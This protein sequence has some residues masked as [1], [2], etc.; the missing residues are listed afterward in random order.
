MPVQPSY[1]LEQHVDGAQV[2]DEQVRVYVQRLFERLRSHHDA[3]AA[4][5]LSSKM[6]LHGGV[7]QL[8]VF[9]GEPAGVQGADA[10]AC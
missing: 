6:R 2:G 8:A 1:A 7:Q 5:A 4:A 3:S 10:V 9:T